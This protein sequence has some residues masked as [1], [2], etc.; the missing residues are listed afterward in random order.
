MIPPPQHQHQ[1][2]DEITFSRNRDMEFAVFLSPEK[3]FQLAQER[4]TGRAGQARGGSADFVLEEPAH[5]SR[6]VENA[7]HPA[8]RPGLMA[9]IQRPE[10]HSPPWGR[11]KSSH[12]PPSP[13]H[14]FLQHKGSCTE[15]LLWQVRQSRAPGD[16][17]CARSF[18]TVPWL[19]SWFSWVL[20]ASC[21]LADSKRSG[22]KTQIRKKL[23][24][25]D[26]F[27]Q[28]KQNPNRLPPPTCENTQTNKTARKKHTGERLTDREDLQE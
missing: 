16:L 7:G 1:L 17:L 15:S 6:N 9:R 22:A 20:L 27:G 21:L 18:A 11:A 3:K 19:L 28:M 13:P 14:L 25:K 26:C 10:Q 24:L 5:S 2:S 23:D 12:P 4:S 8:G